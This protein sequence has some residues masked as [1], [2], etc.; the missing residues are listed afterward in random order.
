MANSS[1]IKKDLLLQCHDY[2]DARIQVYQDELKSVSNDLNSET[3]SSVGDKHE[4][5]RAMLHIEHE[6]HS[7][8]LSEALK[9][10]KQLLLIESLDSSESISQGS[11]IRTNSENFFLSVS[12]GK[13]FVQNELYYAISAASPLGKLLYGK[14]EGDSISFNGKKITILEHM[15]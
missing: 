11:V 5:S 7:K 10:K 15:Q 8:L 13:L 9:T 2:I 14:K 6:R 12:I 4:T 3:K 1:D